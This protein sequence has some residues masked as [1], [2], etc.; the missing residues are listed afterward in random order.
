MDGERREVGERGG[1]GREKVFH[2]ENELQQFS[3]SQET[4]AFN[5]E[6]TTV[7]QYVQTQETVV[8]INYVSRTCNHIYFLTLSLV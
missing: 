1:R 3:K 7:F 8:W 4:I 6:Q 5:S 2:D